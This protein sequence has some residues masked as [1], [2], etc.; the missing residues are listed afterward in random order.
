[1]FEKRVA[2]S[3]LEAAFNI[4]FTQ[5][6]DVFVAH[7]PDKTNDAKNKFQINLQNLITAY[8]QASDLLDKYSI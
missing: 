6:F 1:M 5:L 4:C 7:M 2:S 8:K 3:A